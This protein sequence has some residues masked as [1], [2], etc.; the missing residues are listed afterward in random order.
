MLDIE[1]ITSFTKVNLYPRRRIRLDHNDPTAT[2]ATWAL[3]LLT[4][5]W[6]HSLKSL[7]TSFSRERYRTLTR[8]ATLGFFL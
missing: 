5:M 1:Q 7:W 2:R 4:S 8:F 6:H 3:I